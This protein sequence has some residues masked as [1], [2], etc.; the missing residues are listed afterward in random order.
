[1]GIS[2]AFSDLQEI[3]ERYRQAEERENAQNERGNKS[4]ERDYYRICANLSGVCFAQRYGAAL[5]AHT[6]FISV[7]AERR[8]FT[9][10]RP[11][12]A[13]SFSC[14]TGRTAGRERSP[15]K[16]TRRGSQSTPR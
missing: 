3:P 14:S 16:S 10:E 7:N 15:R 11:R 6:G 9:A 13:T 1:M 8:F 12:T 5:I 4:A 2:S